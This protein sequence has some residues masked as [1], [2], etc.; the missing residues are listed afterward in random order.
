MNNFIAQILVDNFI[1]F[2]HVS[3]RRKYNKLTL[4]KL[5][6]IGT[7]YLKL[8]SIYN[9]TITY[10]TIEIEDTDNLIIIFMGFVSLKYLN[11]NMKQITELSLNS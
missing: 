2:H 3:K 6:L 1:Y 9:H 7:G 5:L 8:T 4:E 11:I 10:L